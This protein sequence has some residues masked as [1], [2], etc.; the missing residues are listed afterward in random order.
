M[1]E[2]P[3]YRSVKLDE[4]DVSLSVFR[5]VRPGQ[6]NTMIRS[7]ERLG[8]LHP[9][10]IREC[11]NGYQ[12]IDGFKRYYAAEQL[13]MPHLL[14]QV[15]HTNE[16]L[17][18]AMILHYNKASHCLIDYE[19]AMVVYSLKQ[20]HLLGQKEIA[21]LLGCSASRVCRRLLL[22]ERLEES[23][24][25]QLRLGKITSA[26]AREIVKLPRCN[27]EAVT[28]SVIGHNITSRQSAILVALCLKSSS[29][30]E[31]EYLL[32]CPAE[33]IEK[34][35]KDKNVYD[36]RLGR[37]GNRLLKTMELLSMQQ[38]IFTGQFNDH[39]T[40]QLTETEFMILQ[41][42]LIRLSEKSKSI[43]IRIHAKIK[44]P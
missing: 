32:K 26:H 27:Q 40:S 36:S 5:L 15:L 10:I 23:V 41:E 20:D 18:K 8:Q 31:Q 17:G 34:S 29:N 28:R 38:H 42:K 30:K 19:E 44:K 6:I 35:L 2:S 22:K 13:Q 14:A 11:K 1:A 37:H 12:L 43:H 7:L 16:A 9:V 25:A 3:S 24:Q 39:Q 21:S 4:I 33:A